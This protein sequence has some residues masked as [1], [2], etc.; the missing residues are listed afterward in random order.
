M[1]HVEWAKGDAYE[2]YAVRWSTRVPEAFVRRLEVPEGG[3]W[4][5]A[6][7]GTGALTAQ[8]LAIAEPA[9]VVG[10]GPV[11]GLPHDG[12]QA[13]HRCEGGFRRGERAVAAVR[14]ADLLRR[15]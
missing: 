12:T 7:C 11:V 2:V 1:T 3:R 8:V 13:D 14:R 5:D 15:S 9:R 4:L 6:G 10:G